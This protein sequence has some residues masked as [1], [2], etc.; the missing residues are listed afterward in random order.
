[1]LFFSRY[2]EAQTGIDCTSAKRRSDSIAEVH[3]YQ[4]ETGF[5]W[6]EIEQKANQLMP[7]ICCHVCSEWSTLRSEHMQSLGCQ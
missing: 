2:L 5:V 1:M 6:E 7:T 3:D 4:G